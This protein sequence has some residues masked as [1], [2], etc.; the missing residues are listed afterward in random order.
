KMMGNAKSARKGNLIAAAGMVVAI[1]ATILLHTDATGNL[2][3]IPMPIYLTIFSAIALG[4]IVGWL[5]AKRVQMTKMPELV[6]MFNGM[7]GACAALIGLMEFHHNIGNTGT[8]IPIVL[9]I[10]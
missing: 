4:T 2:A 9:G 6:S 10:I 1:L 5:T 3:T 7:G 8:L